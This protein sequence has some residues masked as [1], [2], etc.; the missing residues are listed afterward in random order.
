MAGRTSSGR[1]ELKRIIVITLT[2]LTIVLAGA[3][4]LMGYAA[5]GIDRL[6]A[7]K[8]REL[9][10]VRLD[11]TFEGLIEAINSSAIW[12]DSVIT[13]SGEPDLEWLQINFGDYYADFM[14][15]AVTLVHDRHGELILASR[16]SE[17]VEPASEQ[18]FIDAVTPLVAAVRREAAGN[19]DQPR[20]SFDAAVNRTALVRA[21][22]D[23]YLVALGTVVPED[24][25][26]PRLDSDPVIVSAKPI[27]DLLSAL[28]K[29]LAIRNPVIT[30]NGASGSREGYLVL[31][32]PDDAVLGH[33]RWTPD[34]PGLSV[35]Q[36][37][38]P[39]V[40]GLILLLAAAALALFV[41]VHGIVRRLEKNEVDL[42]EARD[43]AEG[44]NVAKSR[45]LANVSH[46]LR[47]PLNGVIGMAEVMAMGELSPIQRNR[48]DVLRE[49]SNNLLRL[50]ERLLQVTRLER[51]EVLVERVVFDPT[52]MTREMAE[53]YRPA[54][55]A[56]GLELTI[57]GAETGLR[58]GDELHVQQ[59]LDFLIDNAI[60]YTDVGQVSI[61]VG[62]RDGAVRFTVMD[63]GMGI[64]PELLPRLFD[65]FVQADDS[66][67]RRFEG[68]GVGL[69]ICRN[70]VEAMGGRITVDSEPG[71]GSTFKVDL[72]LPPA[73]Q[74]AVNNSLAA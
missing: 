5:V 65:V 34:R 61:S 13:L 7:E 33:V 44:A 48:L 36:G 16:D 42:T 29:D 43:R 10:Q 11:R 20:A 47:T 73:P 71:R 1:R 57:D 46:E 26:Q 39:A 15:H 17:P 37:A 19:R 14:G 8:E 35:L 69:S 40:A 49:S 3:V 55:Q 50:I 31:H 66:I 4:G 56:R 68:A 18:A 21:G 59:V 25:T 51:R 52:A 70:L 22:T 12:N 58:L 53:Q 72:P 23:I 74:G 41:R 54:A 60:T 67:T 6:Q 63:T 2:A 64:A 38:A 62:P 28:E 32:G 24:M 27:S 30:N 45:F 9:A